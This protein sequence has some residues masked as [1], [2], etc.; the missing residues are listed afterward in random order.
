MQKQFTKIMVFGFILF[1]VILAFTLLKLNPGQ[2][3][4]AIITFYV[5]LT[6][7]V[8]CLASLV[9]FSARRKVTNNELY[10][11]NIKVSFRQALLLA[12]FIDL[13][14]FIASIN[15]LTWWDIVL[16]A[17]SLI[18]LELYFESNKIK[19]IDN[20]GQGL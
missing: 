10:F 4:F 9:S 5:S 11:A 20:P 3:L 8:T 17:L 19:T 1:G 12:I 15:L 6:L 14:L 2:G 18:L 13:T 7:T 16:L